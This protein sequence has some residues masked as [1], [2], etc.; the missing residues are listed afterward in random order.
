MLIK[1]GQ[2]R[3]DTGT[4][5]I[6][7]YFK[8]RTTGQ[9]FTVEDIMPQIISEVQSNPTNYK[10]ITMLGLIISNKMPSYAIFFVYGFITSNVIQKNNLEILTECS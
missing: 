5:K 8:D 2:I 9:L 10:E 4:R 7:L 1:D 6:T 3:D